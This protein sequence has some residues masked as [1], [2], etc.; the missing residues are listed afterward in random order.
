MDLYEYQARKLLNKSG[1]KVQ[2][3]KLFERNYASLANITQY[4][5]VAKAQVKVG[6]RGKAGGVK[7]AKNETELDDSIQNILHLN[8]KGH[9]VNKVFVVPAAN[10][11]KEMY[12]SIM[13][14]RSRSKYLL[15]FS[16]EGGVEIEE[17]AK[18]NSEAID[19]I[20]FNAVDGLKETDL[21]FLDNYSLN[22]SL[23]NQL[24]EAIL[25]MWE[26]YQEFDATLVEINPLCIT[27]DGV[28]A[29]DAKISLDDN[30]KFRHQ[31]IFS[32]FFDIS[33]EDHLEAKAKEQGI[34][35]V[36]LDGEIGIIG[37]GAGLVMSS[38]D[39]VAL[40]GRKF[41]SNNPPKPANFLDIG[42]GASAEHMRKSLELIAEDKKVSA[43]LINIYGG[44]TRC[45]LVAEGL[46]EALNQ[47]GLNLPIVVRFDGNGMDE[48][49]DILKNANKPNIHTAEDMDSAAKLVVEIGRK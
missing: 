38:L 20:Y 46:L 49:L 12:C 29:L 37:N 33:V 28:E 47:T 2:E 5:V 34:N 32:D 8:I 21:E 9:Q 41:D 39:V 40:A 22:D 30:A 27:S 19:K 25:N 24:K 10:I 42:G 17:L 7:L 6:G 18:T 44:L 36:H 35:Y 23:L 16:F 4:P 31:E 48:G 14:D 11:E 13:Y 1:V 26:C 45:E 43:I 3:G 15:M